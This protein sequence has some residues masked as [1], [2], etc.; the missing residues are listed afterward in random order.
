MLKKLSILTLTLSTLVLGACTSSSPTDDMVPPSN[1]TATT[2]NGTLLSGKHMVTISTNKGDISVELDADLAPK[3]VTNFVTLAESGFYDNLTFH[4]V[5]P[6]FMIQGGDPNGNG[7]GG[8]SI[9]GEKFEDEIDPSNAVYANGYQAGAIAMAN[10]GPNTNGS[11]FFIMD[12]K[13]PLPPNYTI[14]GQVTDGQDVVNTI[15][16]VP[17]G[18]NDMPTDKVTFSVK[19]AK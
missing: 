1:D 8:K 10:S 12:T 14:F 11:Q 9:Y 16:R 19:V 5:I 15:A 2:W 13:Y 6:E 7:T 3:T 4:R 17:R 18:P